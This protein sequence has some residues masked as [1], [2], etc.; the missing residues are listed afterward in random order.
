MPRYKEDDRE[1]AM[2]ETRSALLDAAA[3]EFALEGYNGANINRISQSAGFAK[4][5]VYNYFESKRA[6]MQ[7]LITDTAALHLGYIADRV[8]EAEQA[9]KR[10]EI[11]FSAGFDFV[12]N[13]PARG[14]AIVNNLYGPDAG[15]K[16]EMYLAYL[17]MFELVGRDI[18]ALGVG[19]GIFRPVDPP[20]TANLVMLVYLG[21]ASQV[22]PEGTPWLETHLVADF[23]LRALRISAF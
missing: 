4:G 13:Y 16:E 21:I 8:M 2:S 10:L 3:E 5:T 7:G 11:F 19:Q 1:R 22:S 23:A 20:T 6:L 9:D 15:F 14:Q 12:S 17:P 18:I